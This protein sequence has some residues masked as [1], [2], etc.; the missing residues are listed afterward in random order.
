[1]RNPFL[2]CRG[3]ALTQSRSDSGVYTGY[4]AS[5][6]SR[7][8]CLIQR[9]PR[10]TVPSCVR[11]PLTAKTPQKSGQ[12]VYLSDHARTPRQMPPGQGC[13]P[14]PA[15]ADMVRTCIHSDS[16]SI[17]LPRSD[18]L[19]KATQWLPNPILRRAVRINRKELHIDAV[20]EQAH[21]L[22]SEHWQKK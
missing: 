22:Y 1:M 4:P 16:I 21:K 13:A 18:R 20:R 10:S 8:G 7:D 3:E 6:A 12:D 2:G 11:H 19:A 17:P 5:L 15:D 9:S 14:I